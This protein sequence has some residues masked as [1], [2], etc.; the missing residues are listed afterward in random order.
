MRV[1]TSVGLRID[2]IELGGLDQRGEDGPVLC[3]A[4]VEDEG[5]ARPAREG[6]ADGLGQ[7]GLLADRLELA[8]ESG[9]QSSTIGGLFS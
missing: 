8:A 4:V 6:V 9:L 3:A 7:L 2:L 1:M 5:Q